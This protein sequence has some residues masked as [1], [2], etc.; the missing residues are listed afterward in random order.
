MRRGR[1]IGNDI[2]FKRGFYMPYFL[3]NQKYLVVV[4]ES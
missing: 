4:E 2:I 3:C 1:N